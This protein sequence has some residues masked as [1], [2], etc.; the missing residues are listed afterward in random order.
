MVFLFLDPSG[1]P[2]RPF[3]NP[4]FCDEIRGSDEASDE[5]PPSLPDGDDG[6][7]NQ[8]HQSCGGCGISIL[9]EEAF[10]AW[11]CSSSERLFI[12]ISLS[13][14]CV[15]VVPRISS[16]APEV[17]TGKW[18]SSVLISSS[19]EET[20]SA[21]GLRGVSLPICSR[22][23]RALQ[24]ISCSGVMF[25]DLVVAGLSMPDVNIRDF[26]S[27]EAAEECRFLSMMLVDGLE[28]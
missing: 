11:P 5:W 13:G 19:S 17:E 22:F 28:S 1:L 10:L 6:I 12:V 3:L 20:Q 14:N 24:D 21:S 26:L 16:D 25:E 23:S 18:S 4:G 9:N 8:F 27:S 2:L 7:S 15:G